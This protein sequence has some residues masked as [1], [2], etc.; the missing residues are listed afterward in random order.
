MN[1]RGPWAPV[2]LHFTGRLF[3]VI[4]AVALLTFALLK[5]EQTNVT[6]VGFGFLLVVLVIASTWGF[7]EAA[8][9][10]VLATLSYNY[11]FLPPVGAF[12]IADPQNWI[13]LFS[14]LVTALIA[15][16]LSALAKR[17]AAD[18]LERQRDVERLYTFSRAILLI[19]ETPF[20]KLLA[21]KLAEVFELEAAVLYDRRTGAF[22]RAGPQDLDGVQDQLKE[23]ALQGTSFTDVPKNRVIT[24]VR[25][26]AEPIASLAI[27]GT[28]MPDSVTQGI[29]NL[30]AIGLERARAQDL[31]HEVEAAQRTEQLRTALVDAMAHELKTPLTSIKAATTSLLANPDQSA[32]NR[33]ELLQVADEEADRLKELIDGSLEMARLD[34][35]K[36]EIRAEQTDVVELARDAVAA[37]RAIIDGRCVEIA[38][39]VPVLR[40]EI[41]PRLVKIAV[42]QLLD[43]AL[44]YSPPDSPIQ[45]RIQPEAEAAAIEIVDHGPGIPAPERDRIFERF[46]RSPSV[47]HLIPGSG[48]GLSIAQRIAEAHRGSLTVTSEPGET[49]FR[50]LL[51]IATSAPIS[52][53]RE[54]H[55]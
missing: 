9:A 28:P 5:A 53:A 33:A 18:A 34:A 15:S 2:A 17:R 19:E 26:G 35:S 39:G 6:T 25:L 52:A 13:A 41:D 3:A 20:P 42:H 22:Y 4:G 51:P 50:M 30:V 29:A 44:K 10:A 43:N 24:A 40:A 21:Q 47:H 38:A 16:R 7:I 55:A 48:L 23:S 45:I 1:Q 12:T 36:L 11:F 8:I 32:E 49:T 31:A 54:K 37:R 27:Q 14:F 46:Y